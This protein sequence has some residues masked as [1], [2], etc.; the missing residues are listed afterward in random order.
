MLLPGS[1]AKFSWWDWLM[2]MG[3]VVV[4]AV[5]AVTKAVQGSLNFDTLANIVS[6]VL[7]VILPASVRASVGRCPRPRALYLQLAQRRAY[8][9]VRGARAAGPLPSP[10]RTLKSPPCAHAHAVSSGRCA[11]TSPS[12]TSSASTRRT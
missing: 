2:I 8:V 4:G 6:S 12:P 11:R 3:P 5:S 1:V 9:Y 7:L 10:H